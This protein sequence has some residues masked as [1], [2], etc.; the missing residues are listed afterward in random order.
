M[1][2]RYAVENRVL[3]QINFSNPSGSGKAIAEVRVSTVGWDLKEADVGNTLTYG[4]ISDLTNRN[5]IRD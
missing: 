5:Y 4:Q 1:I 3:M 2:V